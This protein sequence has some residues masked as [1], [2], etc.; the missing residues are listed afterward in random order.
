MIDKSGAAF[1]TTPIYTGD[2]RTKE[3]DGMSLRDYFA[4]QAIG[5]IIEVFDRYIPD[6]ATHENMAIDAYKLADAMLEARKK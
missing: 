3:Y 4:S 5:A 1:P 6:Q 2:R